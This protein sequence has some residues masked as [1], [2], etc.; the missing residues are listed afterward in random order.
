MSVRS[1]DREHELLQHIQTFASCCLSAGVAPTLH[2]RVLDES[3]EA[4]RFHQETVDELKGVKQVMLKRARARTRQMAH[5]WRLRKSLGEEILL[6]HIE[7]P[8]DSRGL[9]KPTACL[10]GLR[11]QV[12]AEAHDAESYRRRGVRLHG[13]RVPFGRRTPRCGEI[14]DEPREVSFGELAAALAAYA[15]IPED[16]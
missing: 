13:P 6:D 14:V 7:W 5:T 2:Q 8:D 12:R 16:M 15:K 11:G 4:E 3:I 10:L 9:P 1:T